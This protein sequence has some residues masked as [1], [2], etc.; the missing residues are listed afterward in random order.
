MEK[1][2]KVNVPANLT[3]NWDLSAIFTLRVQGVI[4]I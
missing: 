4:Q 2:A 3:A 1:G